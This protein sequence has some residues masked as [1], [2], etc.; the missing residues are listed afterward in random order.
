MKLRTDG[1]PWRNANPGAGN[2]GEPLYTQAELADRLKMQQAKLHGLMAK[3]PG[4]KH[5]HYH[6]NPSRS[7]H[8]YRLSDARKWLASLPK[9]DHA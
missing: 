1:T 8:L 2:P 9:E 3:H 5:W 4:L 6:C 7:P